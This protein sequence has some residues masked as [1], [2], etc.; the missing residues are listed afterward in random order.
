MEHVLKKVVSSKYLDD[1]TIYHLNPSGLFIIG[2][3]QG[4]AD[5]Q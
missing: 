2:G 3:Q 5:H 4:D 1:N